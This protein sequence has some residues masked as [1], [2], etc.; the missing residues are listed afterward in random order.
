M[1]YVTHTLQFRTCKS[2]TQTDLMGH[3][4]ICWRT[5]ITEEMIVQFLP[6]AY[7]WMLGC[8]FVREAKA[9]RVPRPMGL[10][11]ALCLICFVKIWKEVHKPSGRMKRPYGAQEPP[12]VAKMDTSLTPK[13]RSRC[14]SRS[15]IN[16]V[17]QTGGP[18]EGERWRDQIDKKQFQTIRFV[19]DEVE[20]GGGARCTR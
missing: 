3:D 9:T 1:C 10:D 11:I 15:I 13:S 12:M 7:W 14:I 6:P 19:I 2:R 4:L 16:C 20:I 8:P 5:E 17:F 18:D